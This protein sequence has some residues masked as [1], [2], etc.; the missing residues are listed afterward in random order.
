MKNFKEFVLEMRKDTY[1][2]ALLLRKA[3]AKEVEERK[4]PKP[5]MTQIIRKTY[6]EYDKK[7][8]NEMDTREGF[9]TYNLWNNRKPCPNCLPN[10]NK[11]KTKPPKHGLGIISITGQYKDTGKYR[12]NCNNCDYEEEK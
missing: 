2:A 8:L 12:W 3:I 6:T 9:V 4:N 1:E 5:T 7:K 10:T 11:F